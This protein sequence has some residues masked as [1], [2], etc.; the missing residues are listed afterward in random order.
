MAPPNVLHKKNALHY[1]MRLGMP[2]KQFLFIDRT[3]NSFHESV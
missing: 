2:V 1:E 3:K